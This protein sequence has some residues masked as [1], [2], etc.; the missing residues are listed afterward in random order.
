[1]AGGAAGNP[2]E[3]GEVKV[4]KGRD[5]ALSGEK[6]SEPRGEIRAVFAYGFGMR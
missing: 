5:S 4:R 3:A 1:M 2:P 6:T